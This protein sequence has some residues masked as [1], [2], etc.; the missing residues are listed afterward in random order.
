M[1]KSSSPIAIPSAECVLK[2]RTACGIVSYAAK[3]VERR[4]IEKLAFWRGVE[5]HSSNAFAIQAMC[6][7]VQFG[8]GKLNNSRFWGVKIESIIPI[9]R[10]HSE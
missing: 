7:P 5:T 4:P 10:R 1:R 2:F 9:N 6:G 8:I 3:Q